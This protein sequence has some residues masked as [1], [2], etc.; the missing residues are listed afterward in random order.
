MTKRVAS[1]RWG[2][3]I[4]VCEALGWSYAEFEAAPYEL[5]DEVVVRLE[6]KAAAERERERRAKA[7][8]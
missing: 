8:R 5:I 1:S 7:T 6:A 4:A 3:V 2:D